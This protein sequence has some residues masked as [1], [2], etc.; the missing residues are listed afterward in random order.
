MVVLGYPVRDAAD[1]VA[2]VLELALNLEQLETLF[3]GVPL[4]AA[5]S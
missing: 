3:R 2:G 4:P 1:A 5:R